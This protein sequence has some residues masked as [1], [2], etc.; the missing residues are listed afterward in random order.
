MNAKLTGWTLFAAL[1]LG[2]GLA[3]CDNVEEY[4]DGAD[5]GTDTDT[6]TDTDWDTDPPID[7]T[8][9]DMLVMVDN[10]SSMQQEQAILSTSVYSLIAALANPLSTS[11]WGAVDEIRIAVVTSDMGFSSDGVN[12]DEF[13]PD[14]VPASCEGFGDN[15]IFRQIVTESVALDNDAIPCDESAAQC[16]DGWTCAGIDEETFVGVC[17]TD[18]STDVACPNLAGDWAE[19]TAAAPNAALI[20]QATCLMDQ[21]TSGCGFEQQLAS[22]DKALTRDD[23]EAF[24]VDGHL[25]MLLV[26]TDEDDCSMEDGEGLFSE[27]AVADDFNKWNI[28]CG[29]H[30]E[31][32][33]SSEHFYQNF[34]AAKG[35]GQVV[36]AAITGV[37]V[38]EQDP[39]GAAACQGW[40]DA[41]G[42]CLAQ[43]AMQLTA[44]Q[45]S[46][47]TWYWKEA[48][49]RTM[50]SIEVTKAYPGRR[51]VNLA[52]N[53][54][55]PMSYVYSICNDD[56][57]PAF[58]D[59]KYRLRQYLAQP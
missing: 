24:L 34:V 32:L 46:G 40:G 53:Y 6:D 2:L 8:G 10:S 20:T 26:V 29:L 4:D 41:L 38:A 47:T 48:C 15:G 22:I 55:G 36:F 7:F 52:A 13:W 12:N 3:A 39:A 42:D 9:L 21:G 45:P 54:F 30:P 17:H 50:D 18:G 31:H 33:F 23:Q 16:P 43:D 5:G 25:L 28:A 49:T 44:V 14:D 57:S 56:W 35:P 37:P 58:D 27:P 51:F 1:A 19:T 11:G 59:I